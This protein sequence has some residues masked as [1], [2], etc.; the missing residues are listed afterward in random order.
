M[1]VS[2]EAPAG[3]WPSVRMSA[4]AGGL[5]GWGVGSLLQL[6]P[7]EEMRPPARGER[8]LLGDD[9]AGGVHAPPFS[10]LSTMASFAPSCAGRLS[11]GGCT[12]TCLEPE[13]TGRPIGMMLAR[14]SECAPLVSSLQTG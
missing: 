5:K 6:E 4:A 3:G 10:G 12:L 8:L 7:R 2:E 9:C 11:G 13:A 1:R 14:K